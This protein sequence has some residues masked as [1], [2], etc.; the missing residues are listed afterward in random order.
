MRS[1]CESVSSVAQIG[2]D[3][4]LADEGVVAATAR[5]TCVVQIEDALGQQK[6]N[7]PAP[8]HPKA[9]ELIWLN[10]PLRQ[11]SRTATRA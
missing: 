11:E 7:K 3:P 4:F 8:E 10:R 6:V 9:R 5:G 2:A 1:A